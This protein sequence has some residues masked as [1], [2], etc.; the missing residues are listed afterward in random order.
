MRR[1]VIKIPSRLGF[2][3]IDMNGEI[4]RIDGG[5]GL[6]LESPYTLIEAV[7]ADRV[8]VKCLDE[9]AFAER[10]QIA[11]KKVCCKHNIP[12]V[13]INILE[14]PL[15]H[16]GLGSAT[17]ALVGAAVAICKLY[18]VDESVTELAKLVGRGGTSG[19]GVGAIQ[20]GGFILDGGHRFRRGDGISKTEYAPSGSSAGM[21]PPPILL[22]QDFPDWD[23]LITIPLGGGISG[24]KEAVLFKVVCPVPLNEVR[25]ICHIIIMQILPAIMERDIR[26]FGG[27]MEEYQKLGFKVFEFRA[28]TKLIHDCM[29]FLRENGGIGV[30]MSSWGPALFSFGEDLSE[31][32]QKA[33]FWLKKHGGGKNILTKANNTGM[34]IVEEE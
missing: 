8:Q 15:P 33:D 11:A 1:I 24:F 7:K 17:Q 22:R 23:V 3:L 10:I 28:Q 2:G 27:G 9:P 12:G 31:L 5:I 14:R 20:Y 26:V 16:V 29:R 32:K 19:I 4:G 13:T 30:G 6:A 18:D 25:H 21:E 34:Q